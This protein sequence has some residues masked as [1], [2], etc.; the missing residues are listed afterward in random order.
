[1]SEG[2]D[3]KDHLSRFQIICKIPFPYLGDRRV[4]KKKKI[5]PWWYPYQTAKI[6][7]QALGRSIRSEEDYADSYILD[8]NWAFFLKINRKYFPKWFLSAIKN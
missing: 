7:V 2:I 6:I 5:Q 3:L 4:M 8:S 1:M